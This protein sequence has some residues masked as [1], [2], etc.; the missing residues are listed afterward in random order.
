MGCCCV[1]LRLASFSRQAL[2]G[3]W[4][5]CLPRQHSTNH[6]PTRI[7]RW[8]TAPLLIVAML[9][10]GMPAMRA[11]AAAHRQPPML[12]LLMASCFQRGYYLPE[13][14]MICL[15]IPSWNRIAQPSLAS[16]FSEMD[17]ESRINHT[18][19]AAV[20][21]AKPLKRATSV[22]VDHWLVTRCTCLQLSPQ[23]L[24]RCAS[25]CNS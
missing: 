1:R 14:H 22:A 7:T 21:M 17:P 25:I 2:Q 3:A 20:L 15:S 23:C 8:H 9:S 11:E 6:A 13:R 5:R 12:L 19:V 16:A 4:M 10:A 18:L 24:I